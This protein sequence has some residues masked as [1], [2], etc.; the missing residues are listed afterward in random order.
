MRAYFYARAHA[1]LLTS[2]R[3]QTTDARTTAAE[4]FQAFQVATLPLWLVDDLTPMG[5]LCREFFALYPTTTAHALRRLPSRSLL[6]ESRCKEQNK[7]YQRLSV[8]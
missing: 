4:S 7:H 1:T 8:G 2:S 5:N 6:I 3:R